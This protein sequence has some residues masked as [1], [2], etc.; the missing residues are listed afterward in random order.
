MVERIETVI[1]GGGLAGLAT[2]YCLTLQGREHMVLE[3]VAHAA[4]VWRTER[5]PQ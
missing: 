3:Q 4:P 1:A 5:L 2:S